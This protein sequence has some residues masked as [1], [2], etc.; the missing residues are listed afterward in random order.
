MG[1]W[2]GVNKVT[3]LGTLG[4]DPEVRY[5]ADNRAVTSFSLATNESWKDRNSGEWQQRAEWHNVVIFGRLAEVA[6]EHLKKGAKTYVEGKLRTRK[7]QGQDGQDRYTTEVVVD[8]GG[9]L[10]LLDRGAGGSVS[11]NSAPPAGDYAAPQQSQQPQ[12]SSAEPRQN[13]APPPPMMGDLDDD[14]PF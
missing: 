6:G 12:Q 13:S 4:K 10:Q 3:L 2:D 1:L 7:W 9:V 11:Y 5:T 8:M 14:I